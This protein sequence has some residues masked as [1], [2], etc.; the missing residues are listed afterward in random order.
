MKVKKLTYYAA[1]V[2][3]Q[4]VYIFYLHT[5]YWNIFCSVQG[6]R[7]NS[8][9][10]RAHIHTHMHTVNYSETSWTILKTHLFYRICRI[11]KESYRFKL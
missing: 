6:V 10:S 11:V 2:H 9:E 3:S 7:K 5:V 8:R 4:S 1:N